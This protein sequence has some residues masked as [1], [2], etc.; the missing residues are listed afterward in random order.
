[1]KVLLACLFALT[2]VSAFAKDCSEEIST[3]A[4]YQ[5][6]AETLEAEDLRLNDLYKKALAKLDKEGKK[7]L[8]K[9]QQMWIPFRDAN[10]EVAADEMRGGTFEKV[11]RIGC[12]ASETKERAD[13]LQDIVEFR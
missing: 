4:I 7:K 9:A 8:Q 12:L 5:C 6:Q 1:M 13:E 3:N 10:C 2:T 11:L